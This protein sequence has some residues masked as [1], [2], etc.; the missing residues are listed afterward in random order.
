MGGGGP[1]LSTLR[2]FGIG[3]SGGGGVRS[4][5]YEDFDSDED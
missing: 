1:S 5:G 3:G 4:G 2:M